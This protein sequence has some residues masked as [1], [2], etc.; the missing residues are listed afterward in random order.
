[1]P[2]FY[3]EKMPSVGNERVLFRQSFRKQLKRVVRLAFRSIDG[4]CSFCDDSLNF[5]VFR[6]YS[7]GG[8]S[9][10]VILLE[11]WARML[12]FQKVENFQLRAL[13]SWVPS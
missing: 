3:V 9:S 11:C 13:E 10:C 1:M 7:K 8:P 6:I 12:C 2:A 5:P 4:R